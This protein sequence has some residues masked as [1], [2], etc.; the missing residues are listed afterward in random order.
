ME[1]PSFLSSSSP[2]T[3]NSQDGGRSGRELALASMPSLT[4]RGNPRT[5]CNMCTSA[6]H[7]SFLGSLPRSPAIRITSRSNL[8][9]LG[10]YQQLT[11]AR[12]REGSPMLCLVMARR[13]LAKKMG[14]QQRSAEWPPNLHSINLL[15]IR[16]NRRPVQCLHLPCL[17]RCSLMRSLHSGRKEMLLLLRGTMLGPPSTLS[18]C[19]RTLLLTTMRSVRITNLAHFSIHFSILASFDDMQRYPNHPLH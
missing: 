3:K 17:N 13:C 16:L 15:L 8:L 11:S 19:L 1:N 6:R 2:V 14:L 18:G 9:R 12:N 4:S 7:T 10:N 5:P